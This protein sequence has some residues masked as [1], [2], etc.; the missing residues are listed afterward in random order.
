MEVLQVMEHWICLLRDHRRWTT[1]LSLGEQLIFQTTNKVEPLRGFYRASLGN[2][3]KRVNRTRRCHHKLLSCGST[4]VEKQT[5]KS[6]ANNR[7]WKSPLMVERMPSTDSK[8][9]LRDL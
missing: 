1:S 2:T 4:N 5:Q 8:K 9:N 7:R 3:V 6:A